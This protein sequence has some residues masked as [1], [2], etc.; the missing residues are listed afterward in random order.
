MMKFILVCIAW[1]FLAGC[2]VGEKKDVHQKSPLTQLSSFEVRTFLSP[3][4]NFDKRP[5]LEVLRAV[6]SNLDEWSLSTGIKRIHLEKTALFY[7]FLLASINNTK[8]GL[9]SYLAK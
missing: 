4:E 9:F 3:Y 7:L 5:A 6:L 2:H 8:K 1:I